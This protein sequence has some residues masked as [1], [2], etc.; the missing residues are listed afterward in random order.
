VSR[1]PDN[2][3]GTGPALPVPS[4]INSTNRKATRRRIADRIARV[5]RGPAVTP[6]HVIHLP[7]DGRRTTD[8]FGVI[9]CPFCSGAHLHRGAPGIR[10]APCRGG[11]YYVGAVAG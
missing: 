8:A 2:D 10:R 7:A 9:G 6:L 3:D 5:E 11:R 4:A 1:P